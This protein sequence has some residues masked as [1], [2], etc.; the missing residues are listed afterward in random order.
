MAQANLLIKSLIPAITILLFCQYSNYRPRVRGHAL[1][2]VIGFARF[3]RGCRKTQ[4][5]KSDEINDLA[6]CPTLG[7][8]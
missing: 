6:E 5:M 4:R 8:F 3:N 1:D 2:E 7:D